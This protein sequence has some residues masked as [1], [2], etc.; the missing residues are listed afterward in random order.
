M[1]ISQIFKIMLLYSNKYFYQT[2]VYAIL[3]LRLLPIWQEGFKVQYDEI[4]E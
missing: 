4:E 2:L 1:R 3:G